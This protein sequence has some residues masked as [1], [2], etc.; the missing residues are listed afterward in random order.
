MKCTNLVAPYCVKYTYPGEGVSDFGCD[1]T[2][3]NAALSIYQTA[4]DYLG[5]TTSTN[6][7]TVAAGALN[8]PTGSSGG[9]GSSGNSGSSGTTTYR[10]TKKPAIGAI[11]GIVIAVLAVLFFIII[12]IVMCMKKKKKQKQI[13]ANNELVAN[14]QANRPQSEFQPLPPQQQ[15]MQQGPSAPMP[16]QSPQPTLNGYFSPPNQQDQKYNGHTSVHEYGSPI[17]NSSTPAPAYVQPYM[18]PNAPPMPQQQS[19]QYQQPANGAHEVPSPVPQQHTGQY[20]APMNGAHE[21]PSPGMSQAHSQQQT[22]SPV[23]QYS[24][25]PVGAHEVDAT[26]VPHAPGKTGP[27]YEMG[28]GR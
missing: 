14:V 26:S 19:G 24:G 27:V 7:P 23:Q 18:A 21:I 5:S 28:Q 8:N 6:L 11:V 25:S 20:Q 15:Q 9:S 12:G 10:T 22:V 1:S 17:S 16:T 3:A 2:S 4:T 13:A